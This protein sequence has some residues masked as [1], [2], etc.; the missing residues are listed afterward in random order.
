MYCHCHFTCISFALLVVGS[1]GESNILSIAFVLASIS[2]T[3]RSTLFVLA[4]S[5]PSPLETQND[6]V[7]HSFTP[8]VSVVDALSEQIN[9]IF[10][11]ACSSLPQQ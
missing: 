6:H 7:S 8:L 4:S 3:R 11:K 1:I 10:N 5:C 2:L 9:K